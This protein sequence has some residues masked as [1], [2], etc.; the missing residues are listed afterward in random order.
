MKRQGVVVFGRDGINYDKSASDER[1]KSYWVDVSDNGRGRE[2]R[3]SGDL[4]RICGPLAGHV[5]A[6]CNP[7]V[8]AAMPA[9]KEAA[10]GT[11]VDCTFGRGGHS[12][13]LLARLSDQGRLF[14]FD[15]D[16]E[17]VDVAR[18]L[19]QQDSRFC[20]IHRPFGDLAEALPVDVELSGVLMDLGVS[21]PQLDEPERGFTGGPLDMR[22]NPQQ[23]EPASRVLEGLSSREFAWILREYGEDKDPLLAARIAEGLHVWQERRG[24]FRNSEELREAV[25]RLKRG[26]DDRSQRPEKL[27]FQAV[28]M[29]INQEAWQLQRVLEASFERLRY[30]GRCAVIVFKRSET[31]LLLRFASAHEEPDPELVEGWPRRRLFQLYPLLGTS[32]SWCLRQVC[33]P[34]A[35]TEQELLYNNRSRSARTYVFE[36]R[37][38]RVRWSLPATSSAAGAPMF[39]PPARAPAFGGSKVAPEPPEPP[40]DM[41]PEQAFCEYFGPCRDWRPQPAPDEPA[42][43]G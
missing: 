21:S 25:A 35:P 42:R 5:P 31:M 38:R 32:K 13:A 9:V 41:G 2:Q 30:G 26:L 15:V 24:P 14:A 8:E 18:R 17:A 43:A 12:A 7:T 4:R 36:K 29:W 23:G 34:I 39:R 11:Y 27:T 3:P 19:E 22:M 33:E 40:P 28:R 1:I 20:I 6:L 10:D 37:R 16:P